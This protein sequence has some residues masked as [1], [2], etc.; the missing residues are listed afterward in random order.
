[1]QATAATKQASSSTEELAR[2]IY[3]LHAYLFA[4]STPDFFRAL[5]EADVTLTQVKLM[6]VLDRP[7]PD[8]TLKD[9]AEEMSFSL[10]G[11]SRSIDAL[12]QRGLVERR[13]DEK[14]RRMKRVRITPKGQEVLRNLNEM[15]VALLQQFVE[16]IPETERRRFLDVLSPI[17]GREEI[18]AYRPEG[19]TK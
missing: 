9:L 7:E 10:A 1:M 18:A 8:R 16:T 12:H 4:S 13:E 14:D 6:H 17:V 3:T 15:R 11:A 5:S 2:E 19:L